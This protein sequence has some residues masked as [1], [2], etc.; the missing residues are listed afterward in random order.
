MTEHERNAFQSE[1][2]PTALSQSLQAD[3]SQQNK[4]KQFAL[5]KTSSF[6]VFSKKPGQVSVL[7][8]NKKS[9]LL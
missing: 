5:L 7:N 3:S 9:F 2:D 8:N 1:F 4:A 6:L